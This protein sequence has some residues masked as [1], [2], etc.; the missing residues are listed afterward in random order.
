MKKLQLMASFTLALA[1]LLTGCSV[2]NGGTSSY[3][4]EDTPDSSVV[5]NPFATNP[6]DE[7]LG[8]LEHGTEKLTDEN[9]NVIPF[10]YNGGTMTLEYHVS[11][12]GTAKNV[13]FLVF[14]DGIPQP[15]KMNNQGESA[16][17]QYVQVEE[18]DVET[19]FT[20]SFEPVTGHSGDTLKL[21]VCSIYNAQFQPDMISTSS[22]GMYE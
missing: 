9:D 10:E 7:I 1:L 19:P 4:Y 13:G 17:L 11:A 14:L 2:Q 20:I 22:Y 6:E 12:S 16:Y 18:D 8:Q 15:W 3:L 5:D 21:T